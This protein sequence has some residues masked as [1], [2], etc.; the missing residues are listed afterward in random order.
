MLVRGAALIGQ[1][2]TFAPH[3]LAG[4]FFGLLTAI[5]FGCYILAI[6]AARTRV[7]AGRLAFQSTAITTTILLVVT[8]LFE[9]FL[10][11]HSLNSLLA[12][13]ALALVSQVGGQGLLAVAIGTLPATFSSLVIFIEAIAAAIFGWIFLGESLGFLQVFGGVLILL[14]IFVAQPAPHRALEKH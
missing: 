1:S 9:P 12:V 4:D 10:L 8:A 11:P 5:F 2:Y 3:R 13:T 14:G 7:G 6:R